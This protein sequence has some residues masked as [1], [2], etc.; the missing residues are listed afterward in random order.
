[1]AKGIYCLKIFAFRHQFVLSK[2]EMSSLW[3]ICLF[4]A[5]NYV[6][7]WFAASVSTPAPTNDLLMLQLIERFSAS[8]DKKIAGV[9]E[10]KIRLHF[11]YLGEDFVALPLF[12]DN[13]SDE[14]LRC[15]APN[16][17]P[18]FQNFSVAQFVT[19]HSL[20]LFESLHLPQE[21]LTAA[22]KT[23]T[24]SADY[25]AAQKTV[26]ALKVVNDCAERA[27]RLASSHQE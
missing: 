25:N 13:V 16:Q 21:F 7:F 12:G 15:L 17:V 4:V 6:S 11:W 1:M 5:T 8:A 18:Q 19:Q 27:V 20:N 9:A 24:E 23:W 22:G 26:R 10:K 14:D 3:Q 2:H